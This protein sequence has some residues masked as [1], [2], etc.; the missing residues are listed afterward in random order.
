MTQK[1]SCGRKA[2]FFQRTDNL[3]DGL[4]MF[5]QHREELHISIPSL[6]MP[7]WL[8]GKPGGCPNSPQCHIS[9]T[10]DGPLSTHQPN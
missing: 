1:T 3:I 5:L 6:E 4:L 9:T 10:G 7:P 8:P 2:H